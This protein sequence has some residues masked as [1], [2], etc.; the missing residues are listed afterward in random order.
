MK[1]EVKEKEIRDIRKYYLFLINLLVI[2]T[3][4][5]SSKAYAYTFSNYTFQKEENKQTK[6][7]KDPYYEGLIKKF[8]SDKKY[9]DKV[10]D[11]YSAYVIDL[12]EKYGIE[13]VIAMSQ[14]TEQ[15][16]FAVLAV[17]PDLFIELYNKLTMINNR[18][19]RAR[20]ALK[21]ANA[22][23]LADSTEENWKENF[24]KLINSS[25]QLD[26]EHTH[27]SLSR[28]DKAKKKLKESV[29]LNYL[30]EIRKD[31]KKY[32]LL[33][34][35]LSDQKA[36]VIEMIIKYPNS[37][38]FLLN[39]GKE[40]L[41]LLKKCLK[42]SEYPEVVIA[43]S[44]IL[45]LEEQKNLISNCKKYPKILEAMKYCG[46]ESYFTIMRCPDFYE[47]LVSKLNGEMPRRYILAYAYLVRQD[48]NEMKSDKIDNIKY[49][50]S[51]LENTTDLYL[52]CSLLAELLFVGS[53][54][55]EDRGIF[56]PFY[57]KCNLIFLHKY[58][59]KALK[60]TQKYGNLLNIASLLMDDWNGANQDIE[61]LF[62]AIERFGDY[63]IQAILEFRYNRDFQ[64]KILN[65]CPEQNRRSDLLMFLYYD[66]HSNHSLT[67][68]YTKGLDE[69][70]IKGILEEY[71]A[72][73]YT[74]IPENG[75][76][77]FV[78]FIPGYDIWH[79]IHDSI[80]YGKSPT[81][82]DYFFS[83]MDLVDLV[84]M[85]I[86]AKT[87]I[88]DISKNGL[89]NVTKYGLQNMTKR[90]T[91][92]SSGIKDL[93]KMTIN[94][95]DNIT[96]E[97][98]KTKLIDLWADI[99]IKMPKFSDL[100]NYYAYIKNLADS[101]KIGIKNLIKS[102][103]RSLKGLYSKPWKT[104]YAVDRFIEGA[105]SDFTLAPALFYSGAS[106]L[107]DY[108]ESRKD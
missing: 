22:F 76:T 25:S 18:E 47:K 98:G 82:S 15:S 28:I 95:F 64:N 23:L 46:I 97:L 85:A 26:L 16:E 54:N 8:K 62:V 87:V 84:P 86:A 24:A 17:N 21:L 7:A 12:T 36:E 70:A 102:E 29:P 94:S 69:N 50:E 44:F 75:K 91:S 52:I 9:I 6:K 68:Q 88:V 30:N 72:K 107:E 77:S 103:L 38:S 59:Q 106:S 63:A 101:S 1:L 40:G 37:I 67:Q 57:D 60:L 53:S 89:K 4:Y 56:A 100:K 34:R 43:L 96:K 32:S 48:S 80:V 104:K 90:L 51:H 35:E 92:L 93:G 71:S 45:T 61:P 5:C 19:K 81:F 3:L 42:W 83:A 27:N 33:L 78:E 2:I 79:T 39:T 49:I 108:L 20:N 41:E 10:Y 105:V 58:G 66:Q 65:V 11:K 13:T 31:E 99:T 74:G 14:I 55:D 73:V